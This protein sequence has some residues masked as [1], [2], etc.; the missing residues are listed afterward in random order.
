M[1]EQCILG[2]AS[3]SARHPIVPLANVRVQP[4]AAE[5]EKLRVVLTLERDPLAIQGEK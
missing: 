2:M 3:S 5:F 1:V 4:N